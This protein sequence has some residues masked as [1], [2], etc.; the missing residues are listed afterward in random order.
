MQTSNLVDRCWV[1][2]SITVVPDWC[3]QGMP[4]YLAMPVQHGVLRASGA[5]EVGSNHAITTGARPI[6]QVE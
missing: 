2:I 4:C 1:I 6:E 5:A 3:S